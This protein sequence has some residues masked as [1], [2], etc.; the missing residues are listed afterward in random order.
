MVCSGN[1]DTRA[2]F[3][4]WVLDGNRQ[5]LGGNNFHPVSSHYSTQWKLTYSSISKL[6]F[7]YTFIYG[8]SSIS[9]YTI[10]SQSHSPFINNRVK[11]LA[12]SSWPC[13]MLGGILP[14]ITVWGVIIRSTL[15]ASSMVT[16]WIHPIKICNHCFYLIQAYQ[17]HRIGNFF[18]LGD[19]A[20]FVKFQTIICLWFGSKRNEIPI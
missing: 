1:W 5:T 17:W 11:F 8:F 13:W 6:W 14:S 20:E 12:Q 18:R 19:L 16:L 15:I 9:T 7:R 2:V 4:V 10:T 3:F